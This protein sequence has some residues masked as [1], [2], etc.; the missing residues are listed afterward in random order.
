MYFQKHGFSATSEL[1]PQAIEQ[2]VPSHCVFIEHH[3]IRTL[4]DSRKGLLSLGGALGLFA[5]ALH[6]LRTKNMIDVVNCSNPPRAYRTY[7]KEVSQHHARPCVP[8]CDVM[9]WLEKVIVAFMGPVVR[10]CLQ[11][12][13]SGFIC[14]DAPCKSRMHASAFHQTYRVYGR[15]GNYTRCSG[16]LGIWSEFDYNSSACCKQQVEIEYIPR[17]TL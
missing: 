11:P 12:G 6:L 17:V 5:L 9:P 13:D 16:Q 10:F 2:D 1:L 7:R 3:F 8:S 4:Y 15:L 14:V